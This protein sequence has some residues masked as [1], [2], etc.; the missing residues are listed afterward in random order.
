MTVWLMASVDCVP[1]EQTTERCVIWALITSVVDCVPAEQTTER[2]VI[3]AWITSV[4]D[5]LHVWQR[6]LFRWHGVK[7]CQLLPHIQVQSYRP[8]TA[9]WSGTRQHVSYGFYL[10]QHTTSKQCFLTQFYVLLI[11]TV[12]CCFPVSCT[13]C[14]C[15][16]ITANAI[17]QL[18][19]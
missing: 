3:W 12:L 7:E 2:C 11:I 15:N 5:W 1:A 6:H 10:A 17:C 8:A 16:N 14:K 18:F 9:L 4:V 19:C 13:P